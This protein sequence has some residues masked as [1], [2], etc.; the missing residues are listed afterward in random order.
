MLFLQNRLLRQV[1]VDEAQ[2]TGEGDKAELLPTLKTRTAWPGRAARGT[3]SHVRCV[4][5][6]G[7]GGLAAPLL[8]GLSR[9]EEADASALE[10]LYKGCGQTLGFPTKPRGRSLPYC[11]TLR[12]SHP[13]AQRWQ[14]APARCPWGTPPLP[15]SVSCTSGQNVH[16]PCTC[17][18]TTRWNK[19]G[20]HGCCAGGPNTDSMV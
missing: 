16:T 4:A 1:L 14:P 9:K 15:G 5:S 18:E 13:S 7:P 6:A 20:S 17:V 8:D 12:S 11:L 3:C 19:S 2:Q 10:L